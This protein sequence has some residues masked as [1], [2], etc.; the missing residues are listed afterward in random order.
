MNESS[1]AK[2]K[3]NIFIKALDL[4]FGTWCRCSLIIIIIIIIYNNVKDI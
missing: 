1:G 3:E 4:C 2:K